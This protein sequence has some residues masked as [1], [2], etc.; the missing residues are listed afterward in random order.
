MTRKISSVTTYCLKLRA[1]G[2]YLGAAPPGTSESEYFVRPPWLSL[3]SSRFETLLVRIEETGGEVGWGEALAPV[4]PEVPQAVVDRLLGPRLLGADPLTPRP[5][6]VQL[7]ALMRERGHLVGHQADALAA[8]DI[9]LWDLAGRITGLPVA[10]L[11]GGAFRKAIPTYVSG[12]PRPTDAERADLAREWVEKGARRVKLALGYGVEQDL[13]TFDAVAAAGPGLSIAI[14]AHWAYTVAEAEQLGF[15]LDRR[16]GWF[17]EAPLVPEDVEGHRHLAARLTTPVAVGETLRNRYEFADWLARRAVDLCQPDV[18]RTGITE[19][20]AVANLAQAHHVR[21]A[22][23]HSVGLGVALAA[24]LHLAA[25][26]ENLEAF[27]YQPST[28]PQAN[29]ILT[30]ELIP[31]GSSFNLPEGPGLGISVDDTV[32]VELAAVSD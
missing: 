6:S 20:F 27:E 12:L 9:A 17:L 23:H 15:G 25:A 1:E 24:G 28:L 5:V 11:L 14:D 16:H 7:A 3:Y 4:G 2:P 10:Q 29:R 22:P 31:D 8:C 32:V 18:G 21:V 19:A 26:V 13:A 30:S